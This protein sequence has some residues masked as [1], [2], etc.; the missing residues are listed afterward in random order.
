M[1][2][3]IIAVVSENRQ[4]KRI[5]TSDLP[6][7]FAKKAN[8]LLSALNCMTLGTIKSFDPETQSAEISINYKRVLTRQQNPVGLGGE[9][10]VY[11]D[12]PVLVKCPVVFL[13]GGAGQ[14][15]M[16]V[17]PGDT[18]LVFFADRDIDA[19][20]T[21]GQVAGPNSDRMHDL[22]DGVALVGIRSLLN[23]VQDYLT[24]GVQ[25]RH[26]ESR[27]ILIDDGETKTA[28]LLTAQSKVAA[29]DKV[30]IEAG[31]NN[32]KTAL[33]SLFDALIAATITGGAFSGP[34]ITAITDAKA[35][36]DAV[37]K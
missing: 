18:C 7:L 12:Y 31:V 1:P 13:F 25:L 36:V 5:E 3:E 16:P 33:D 27:V 6:D 14:L 21:S 26:G 15:T 29:E 22:S 8:E 35:A 37:L 23:P 30:R 2:G 17:A 24:N 11:V 4:A 28:T 32:L 34:T 9:G 10:D 19:W 20:Y